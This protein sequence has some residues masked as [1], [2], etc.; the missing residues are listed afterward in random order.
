MNSVISVV[1]PTHN[2]LDGLKKSLESLLRQ[3]Q[4]PDEVIV[5][6]DG[7]RLAVEYSVFE[8]FPTQVK[9]ILLRNDEPKGGNN[10]RN[11]GVMA[12]SGD[13]IAFL[14]D[15]D[16]FKPNK[17]EVLQREIAK[18]ASVD[19][20]YHPAHIHMLNEGVSYISKPYGFSQDEDVYRS[21]LVQNRIGGTPMVTV[22]KQALLDVGL[23]DE[24]MPAMQDYELWLRLAKK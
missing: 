23:F 9:C 12:A 24:Q 20:F 2:R 6:D 1:I 5:V 21:L 18:N 22:R 19:V 17:V 3:K 8:G 7:S 4:L 15:D 13:Y 10:A 16:Q 14:D 11:Q